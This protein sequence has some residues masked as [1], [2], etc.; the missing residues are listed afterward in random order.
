MMRN[1]SKSTLSSWICAWQCDTIIFL[2][3]FAFLQRLAWHTVRWT[4]I[5]SESVVVMFTSRSCLALN[6]L[7]IDW[8]LSE[9]IYQ[10]IRNMLMLAEYFSA[11]GHS[12]WSESVRSW[13]QILSSGFFRII[14]NYQ[15]IVFLL[16]CYMY[17][18]W[19]VGSGGQVF[20]DSLHGISRHFLYLCLMI[21]GYKIQSSE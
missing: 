9:F 19:C 12:N 6:R 10:F 18:A 20:T 8:L 17:A 15:A 4:W 21:S 11:V 2:N 7:V 16:F 3:F 13:V 1:E 14:S 5:G